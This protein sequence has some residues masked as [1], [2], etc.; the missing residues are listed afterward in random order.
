[1]NLSRKFRGTKI[2]PTIIMPRLLKERYQK[3]KVIFKEPTYEHIF[4]II[5]DKV[6]WEFKITNIKTSQPRLISLLSQVVRYTTTPTRIYR[7]K[8][9]VVEYENNIE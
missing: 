8:N 5:F 7:E 1:M 3:I 9:K 4:E 2:K 6:L